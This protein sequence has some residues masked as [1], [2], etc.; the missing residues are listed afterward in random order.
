MSTLKPRWLVDNPHKYIG[1]EDGQYKWQSTFADKVFY[2]EDKTS[3][4]MTRIY[5]KGKGQTGDHFIDD[6]VFDVS[7]YSEDF[8]DK[9]FN[10]PT[11]DETDSKCETPCP[12]STI[13]RINQQ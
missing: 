4:K 12:A 7:T 6:Q 11:D 2:Y 10:L 13:C 5:L 1:E 9:I 3:R 8:D